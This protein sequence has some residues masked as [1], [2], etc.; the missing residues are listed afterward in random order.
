MRST[1]YK[2]SN[3]MHCHCSLT[4]PS[5]RPVH[6]LTAPSLR[7]HCPGIQ[8]DEEQLTTNHSLDKVS[9]LMDKA[10]ESVCGFISVLPGA[11][12]AYRYCAIRSDPKTGE[13]PLT[14]YFKV[15]RIK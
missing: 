15:V 6:A 12:S 9:N 2:M 14:A 3:L 4:V 10:L 13:G 1:T 5:L 11:F 8:P 7:P